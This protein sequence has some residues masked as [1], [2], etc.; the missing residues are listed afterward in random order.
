MTLS[1]TYTGELV[2]VTCWCGMA[3]GIP[4]GLREYQMRCF[5]SGEKIPDVFCPL[6]HSHQPAGES[7]VDAERRRRERVEASLTHAKDQLAA[8]K[9]AHI[10]TK[11][12]LTK[13]RKRIGNGV[14]PCC[15]R[16]FT[17]VERHMATQHPEFVK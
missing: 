2:V 8:E 1:M 14:C 5:N 10:S 9:N 6:G 16:H 13:A 15:N 3:H 12:Q 17:N 11:G 4:K 7:A